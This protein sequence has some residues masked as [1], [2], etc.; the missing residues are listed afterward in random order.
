MSQAALLVAALLAAPA[1]AAPVGP[2]LV[3]RAR[4]L[5]EVALQRALRPRSGGAP[6]VLLRGGASVDPDHTF[7]DIELS[8]PDLEITI[9]LRDGRVFVRRA[10]A[11][12][13]PRDIARLVASML[14]AIEGDDLAP[15]P[16]RASSPAL[17]DPAHLTD[18]TV[19]SPDAV[20]VPERP[21]PPAAVLKNMSPRTSPPAPVLPVKSGRPQLDL[22][23]AAA[24]LLGLTGFRGAGGEIR[25]DLRGARSW[26][27]GAGVRAIGDA[28]AHVDPAGRE[29]RFG[30][31]RIRLSLG[32]G[33]WLRR[34][35]FELRVT[36]GVS[37][38]P[39]RVTH[40][41]RRVRLG[42]TASPAP[43]LGGHLR[44]APAVA[45]S[46]R[47]QLGVFAEFAV[48]AAPSGRAIEVRLGDARLF[49]MGG[50]ESLLGL[51]FRGCLCPKPAKHR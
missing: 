7:I 5:D 3:V 44:L 31:A 21:E 32:G 47:L 15:L 30:L 33:A 4:G 45:L 16:E 2:P 19:D 41:G 46:P 35:R 29:E 10:V 11:P 23:L 37:V 13:A 36:A 34:G 50:F 42:E 14:V 48:T 6:V 49:A 43:L 27:V 28:A 12:D 40:R 8:P 24:P 39:W 22:G 17:A 25:L 26:L 51:E 9:I 20:P 38:E 18:R 1:P